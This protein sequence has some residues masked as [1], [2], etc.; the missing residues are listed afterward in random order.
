MAAVEAEKNGK[1]GKKGRKRKEEAPARPAG[2]PH[3]PSPPSNHCVAAAVL[4]G[5][6][7]NKMAFRVRATGCPGFCPSEIEGRPSDQFER[8]R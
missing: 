2:Q 6:R 5:R 7:R 4:E 3:P 8:S 1:E